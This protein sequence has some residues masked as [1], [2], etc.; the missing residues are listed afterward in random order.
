M[1]CDQCGGKIAYSA[2]RCVGFKN[3]CSKTCTLEAGHA[4]L[5]RPPRRK[6][7]YPVLKE[8]GAT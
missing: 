2:F 3:Y 1:K 5:I 4:E 8:V 7:I 6:I